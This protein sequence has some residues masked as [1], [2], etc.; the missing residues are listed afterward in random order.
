[1]T[2]LLFIEV[3]SRGE[4]KK[5]IKTTEFVRAAATGFF[6][7]AILFH[8]LHGC[9]PGTA[10]PIGLHTQQRSAPY[11]KN[12]Q[13]VYLKNKTHFHKCR[14]RHHEHERC[15]LLPPPSPLPFLHLPYPSLLPS[16]SSLALF[17]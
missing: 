2:E 15:S 10:S 9:H 14:Y 17:L 6:F 11:A 12:I 7:V 3:K 16:P 5:S 8:I 4:K 13:T 1:M